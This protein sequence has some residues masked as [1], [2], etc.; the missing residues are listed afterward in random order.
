[1]GDAPSLKNAIASK[2]TKYSDEN[3]KN[4]Q[5][6]DV[7]RFSWGFFSG[8]AAQSQRLLQRNFYPLNKVSR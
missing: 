5:T 4:A 8:T 7:K 3:E 6:P 2:L 1:M